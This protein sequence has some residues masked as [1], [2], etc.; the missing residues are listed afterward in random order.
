MIDNKLN[1]IVYPLVIISSLLFAASAIV[2]GEKDILMFKVKFENEALEKIAKQNDLKRLRNS[3]VITIPVCYVS[4]KTFSRN[5]KID[6][7]QALKIDSLSSYCIFKNSGGDVIGS[8]NSF[9]VLSYSFGPFNKSELWEEKMID[10][11]NKRYSKNPFII[12]FSDLDTNRVVAFFNKENINFLDREMRLVTN[13]EDI[14]IQQNGTIK[15]FL[16]NMK[17]QQTQIALKETIKTPEDAR[18]FLR[19]DYARYSIA[20]PDDTT[21]VMSLLLDE[22]QNVSKTTHPQVELIRMQV[23]KALDK[24]YLMPFNGAG[25]P[26]FGY[27]ISHQLKAVLTNEQYNAFMEHQEINA[28]LA[29]QASDRIYKYLCFEKKVS[30]DKIEM[31]FN[32]YV[33]GK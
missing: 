1:F 5:D 27:N 14:I 8:M 26:F 32:K 23:S 4:P 2:I 28:W 15:K 21:Q 12:S 7:V 13:S 18:E 11:V 20:F 16:E 22:I 24:K 6:I 30:Q 19:H 25:I 3:T 10:F 31:E 17:L 33:F 29:V 9:R